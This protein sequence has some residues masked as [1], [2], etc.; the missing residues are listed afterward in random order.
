M[1]SGERVCTSEYQLRQFGD[2]SGM[3]LRQIG[4]H[5]CSEL[6]IYRAYDTAGGRTHR[7][8]HSSHWLSTQKIQT[9]RLAIIRLCAKTAHKLHP[10]PKISRCKIRASRD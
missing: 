2:T 1:V 3:P 8:R 7:L 5:T 10:Q 9:G 4:I 6:P